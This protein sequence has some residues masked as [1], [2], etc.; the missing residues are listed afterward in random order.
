MEAS[1]HRMG[2][3][4][5]SLIPGAWLAG[6]FAVLAAYAAVILIPLGGAGVQDLFGRWVYD[7]VVLGAAAACLTRAVRG[8]RERG[9]WLALGAAML[10]WALGQTYYSVFLYYASPAPYPSPP[11]AFFLAFYPASY[12]G[13]VLLMRSRASHL[14]SLAWVDGLIGALAVAAVAAALIL[15]PVLDALG[16]SALGVAV[17]LAYPIADLFLLG[18]VVGA[19]AVSRWRGRGVWLLIAGALLLF[20]S[21]AVVY[22]SV[23]GHASSALVVASVVG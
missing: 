2:V 10:F 5:A 18:M 8:R 6:L 11:D 19:L 1:V 13:L 20:G 23:C 15:P 21:S 12:V 9:A 4:R 7:L 17:S 14:E 16:G 22:L 3:S